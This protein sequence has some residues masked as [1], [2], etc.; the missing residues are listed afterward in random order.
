MKGKKHSSNLRERV[1]GERQGHGRCS[2]RER[3]CPTS[4]P[5][6]AVVVMRCCKVWLMS[7]P[8]WSSALSAPVSEANAAVLKSRCLSPTHGEP[9]SLRRSLGSCSHGGPL[10][11]RHGSSRPT[12]ARPG[13]AP[14]FAASPGFSSSAGRCCWRLPI[15]RWPAQLVLRSREPRCCS[16]CR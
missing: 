2:L 11:A 15:G 8:S 16:S 9:T 14:R 7:W 1:Q 13:Q 6:G 4:P 12:A 5:R 3:G 10:G